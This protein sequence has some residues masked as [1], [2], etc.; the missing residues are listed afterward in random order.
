MS[1]KHNLSTL[2]K[3][4]LPID[5]QELYHRL[6]NI[7]GQ[8]VTSLAQMLNIKLDH[9]N[10]KIKGYLGQMLEL[11]LGADGSNKADVDFSNL[12]LELKTIS[13]DENLKPLESPFICSCK[14]FALDQIDFYQSL[15]YRKVKKIL[16]VLISGKK[17]EY[18][19][20][21]IIKAYFIFTPNAKQ[22]AIIKQD[23]DELMHYICTGRCNEIN[24]TLGT[25]IQMRP[26]AANGQIVTSYLDANGTLSYTRPRGFYMR[27]AFIEHLCQKINICDLNTNL[28]N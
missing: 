14:L 11:Y 27:R 21:K 2:N 18:L 3:N 13:T 28:N 15:L 19:G 6:D 24:A 26:K 23:Y 25:I 12:D 9:N 20:N 16:F 10:T 7:L 8:N 17:H 22:L 4:S 1:L 5:Y